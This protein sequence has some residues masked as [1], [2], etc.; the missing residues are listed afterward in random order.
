MSLQNKSNLFKLFLLLQEGHSGIYLLSPTFFMHREPFVT[1]MNQ[2]CTTLFWNGDDVSSGHFCE[3]VQIFSKNNRTWI[4]NK[5]IFKVNTIPMCPL[6]TNIA[7]NCQ[8]A[9]IFHKYIH[10]FLLLVVSWGIVPFV[11]CKNMEFLNG[12]TI[13]DTKIKFHQ[14]FSSLLSLFLWHVN[15]EP[16]QR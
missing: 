13:F 4:V 3:H 10:C 5:C 11:Q 1:F 7:D 14:C 15:N 16:S 6:S 9:D 8:F 12:M 2:S